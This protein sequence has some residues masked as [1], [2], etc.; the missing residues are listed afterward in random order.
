M[1]ERH[2]RYAVACVRI[3][4]YNRT[5]ILRNPQMSEKWDR[6]FLELARLYS[7]WSKD[8]STQ[9]G[10]VIVRGKNQ[11]GQG[12]N[13]F[14][15][16][17]SDEPELYANR[18]YKYEHVIHG[19]VNALLSAAQSVRGCTLYTVPFMPCSRCAAIMIQAGI[20]RVV[21]Y[22]NQNPRWRVS[23]DLTEKSFKDAGVELVL[24]NKHTGEPVY[25]VPGIV[26]SESDYLQ[27]R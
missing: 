18:E 21:S 13:G 14:S 15:D 7:T 11:I 2:I 12:Y 24:Y 3:G 26:A 10:A 25:P 20:V 17:H 8:P 1:R 4:L 6:R 23:F 16:K 19:E 5:Y 27:G 9:V 22:D